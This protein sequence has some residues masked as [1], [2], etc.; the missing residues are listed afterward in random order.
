MFI[1]KNLLLPWLQWIEIVASANE[2]GAKGEMSVKAAS[3]W[4]MASRFYAANEVQGA[5][6]CGTLLMAATF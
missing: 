1:K 2:D 5:R 6:Y 3:S 4:Q